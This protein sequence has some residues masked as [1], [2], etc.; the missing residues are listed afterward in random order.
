MGHEFRKKNY[1]KSEILKSR[2][3][4]WT[5]WR[6]AQIPSLRLPRDVCAKPRLSREPFSWHVS[7]VGKSARWNMGL[8]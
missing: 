6:K 2:G 5:Q 8:K 3:T 7:R 1:L 4:I